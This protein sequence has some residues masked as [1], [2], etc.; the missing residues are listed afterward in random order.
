MRLR[1]VITLL[2][3]A[4][5]LWIA[6]NAFQH[7]GALAFYTLFSLAPL[8]IIFVAIVG[9]VFGPD[10]ARGEISDAISGL[11]GTQAAGAVE[12]AVRRSRVEEAGML[13]TLIG[14]G[15]LVFG[16]TTVFAQIQGSL[17]Q[18]WGV[19]A[20]PSRSGLLVFLTTRLLSLGMVLII[21][22]LLLI[23]FAVSMMIAAVIQYAQ[24]WVPVPPLVIAGLDVTLSLLI[25]TL[26]FAMMFKILPD[27]HL[28]WGDV[29]R[30]ALVTAVLFLLGQYVI[31]LYLT[32]TAP[33]STYGAAGSLVMVLFWVY[34]AGLILFFGASL[35]RVTIVRRY[36]EVTPKSTAV[37]VEV[38]VRETDKVRG[39]AGG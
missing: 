7:A 9:V 1:P 2:R 20:R 14:V 5:E 10:A 39:E 24:H 12:D 15:V 17:N 26:L 27:V 36:G 30:A 33:T 25:S 18:F 11:V 28:E 37:A 31:S 38:V 16:A 13:P 8:V 21:G 4:G 19:V 23:S 34:Y 22:F 3:E 6:Q 32:M 29:W 35:A